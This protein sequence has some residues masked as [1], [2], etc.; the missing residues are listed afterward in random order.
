MSSEIEP[1]GFERKS[2]APASKHCIVISALRLDALLKTITGM[3]ILFLFISFNAVTPSI[4]GI[5]TS[6][7]TTS[8]LEFS[9]F[10]KNSSPFLAVSIT[11]ISSSLL[12]IS[13]MI[14]LI[15]AESSTTNTLIFLNE[16]HSIIFL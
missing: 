2:I 7:V 14:F 8:I 15:K 1:E 4:L 9:N 12:I 13:D 11:S 3:L 16:N 5:S 6:K 10:F